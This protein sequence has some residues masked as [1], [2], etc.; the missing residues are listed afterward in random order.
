MCKWRNTVVAPFPNGG[1]KE[2]WQCPVKFYVCKLS[3]SCV[4]ENRC[5][6]QFP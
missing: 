2:L 3:I 1:I 4:N 5:K 6:D